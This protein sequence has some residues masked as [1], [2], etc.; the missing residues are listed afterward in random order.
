M[1]LVY[2]MMQKNKYNRVLIKDKELQ[3]WSKDTYVI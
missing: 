2:H 1:Y 3:I